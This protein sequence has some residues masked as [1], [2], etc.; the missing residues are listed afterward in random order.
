MKF[1]VALT[2]LLSMPLIQ[3]CSKFSVLGGG[4]SN[5]DAKP[6]VQEPVGQFGYNFQGTNSKEQACATGV[7]NYASLKEM[8]LNIQDPAQNND[9]AFKERVDKFYDAGCDTVGIPFFGSKTCEVT[10]LP[11]DATIEAWG[12]F[13]AKQAIASTSSCAGIATDGSNLPESHEH[14]TLGGNV[15][16]HIDLN[17]GKDTKSEIEIASLDSK[18]QKIENPHTSE[19]SSGFMSETAKT[20]DGDYTYV[21]KCY[22]TWACPV[23]KAP[24]LE[25]GEFESED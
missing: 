2:I 14:A 11:K 10:L 3:G 8:C 12:Q 20:T 7:R 18:G 15:L 6:T 4:D 5:G 23:A 9:C 22:Q 17:S 24:V 1:S 21:V 25:Q 19:Y 13:D 16:V